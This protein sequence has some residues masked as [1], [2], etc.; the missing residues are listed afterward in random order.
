M[1]KR[2][3]RKSLA[4]TPAPPKERIKGSKKNPVGSASSGAKAKDIKLSEKTLNSLKS[5]LAKFKKD[6]PNKKNVSLGD[7]KKVYRRGLGAYSSTHR[8]T[9]TGGVPNT[10]NAWAMARVNKF[11]KKAGG[12]KVKKA[13]V[14]DDDLMKMENGGAILLAPNE[15]PSNLTAEQYKLVRTPQFKAWFGDWENDPNNASKVVDKN[16]EPLVVYHGS[17]KRF[18]K[19]KDSQYDNYIFFTNDKS[20]SE[21]YGDYSYECFMSVKKLSNQLFPKETLLENGMD[22]FINHYGDSDFFE[23]KTRVY[24]A[25][26]SN[27]IKLAD[28]SNITFDP[29]K[30]DIRYAKGGSMDKTITCKNCG[31]S[32]KESQTTLE[33][34]YIC[35]KCGFDNQPYYRKEVLIGGYEDLT[36]EW[37]SKKIEIFLDKVKP[38]KYYYVDQNTNTLIVGFDKYYSTDSAEKFYNEAISSKEFFNADSVESTYDSKTGDTTFRIKLKK[39]VGYK[40]GGQM[41]TKNIEET[42]DTI[43]N[44]DADPMVEG[45]MAKGGVLSDQKEEIYDK[46]KDLIN[47]SKSEL[48]KFYNSEEGKEAGISVDTAKKLGIS[49]GRTSAKWIMKMK[50]TPVSKWTPEMWK[51][52]S[53]QISFVSRMRG[54]KGELYDDNGKKTRKH[55]SLLIWGHNP[56][57]YKEGGETKRISLEGYYAKGGEAKTCEVIRNGVRQIDPKSIEKL[58]DCVMR[59]PQTKSMHLYKDGNYTAERKQL[60]K[61]IIYDIKKDLTCVQRSQPIAILMGG[62]P[63]SGKSTFLKKYRPYLLSEEILKVDADEVRSKLPEY[64]GWNATQTHLETKDIVNLLLSDRNIGIP[65]AF[66]LIYDGTMNSTKSY[67]PLIKLLKSLGYKVFIVYIDN[68][69]EDVIKERALK[70]YQNSG[71]FVPLE[72]IDDF[73]EKG[74]AALESLK[75]EVDGYM[76]V[77]GSSSEYKVIDRGGLQ[78]PKDRKYS[79]IGTPIEVTEEEVVREYKK[80]GQTDF[81]PDGKKIKDMITHKSGSAGGMLVGK[82]HSEG[83]IKAINKSTGQ[84][85]EMEGGEVVITRDAVSDDTKREFEGEMLTNRE[86]LSRINESGGGVSFAEGGDV[87]ECGC[88]GKKYNYGG[89]TMTDYDILKEMKSLYP[90]D[91]AKGKKEELS[92]HRG[93]FEKLRRKGL[94]ASQAAELVV[95]EHLKKKPDYYKN[96]KKGGM[97]EILGKSIP[98]MPSFLEV[99]EPVLTPFKGQFKYFYQIKD[100][101]GKAVSYREGGHIRG[102]KISDLLAY[103]TYIYD[104]FDINFSELPVKLQNA[105]TLGKQK[106]VDDYLKE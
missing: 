101:L 77:D 31:W 99:G 96:Y 90:K 92:E 43:G 6:N 26:K 64:K 34:K 76:V 57:K 56:E 16:G 19:F 74:T 51:W 10:R 11:L 65:C 32:W 81:N 29:K 7:T 9:I 4:Q 54:N 41:K 89:K 24:C 49:R 63:A 42:M 2:R 87:N 38:I 25:I 12:E 39:E 35:H 94:T 104:N 103:K 15:K 98:S 75:S 22:G 5:K 69:D 68:V 71:R 85:L 84:P 95:A 50:D 46:W 58:T 14:Q 53:K 17:N 27:Q 105:L 72:V 44:V 106:L 70:R 18:T 60:H 61:K 73:F 8:P 20:H 102:R 59:L 33:D 83:G 79:K 30:R 97:I 45:V 36:D 48:E 21:L 88:T 93:T 23:E 78:L 37:L 80:G 1:P 52:A 3:G 47:M 62:S 28:G 82:R 13:Y 66:D 67:L 86:I 55:T 100:S 91:F 40:N